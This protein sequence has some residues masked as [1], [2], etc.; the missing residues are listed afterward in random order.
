VPR[1]AALLVTAVLATPA[2]AEASPPTYGER[3]GAHSML[4]LNSTP[5]QHE[6]LFRS[7]S[8]AGLRYLRMDFA[9][10]MVFRWDGTDFTAVDRVNELAARYRIR[11][12]G[13]IAETPWYIAGCTGV[14][15]E[16]L[17]RCAPAAEHE[18]TWRDMV[19]QIVRR[20][21]NV[22]HWELGNEPDDPRTFMGT[23]ADYAR[24]ASLTADGI[25][26]ARPR[27]RI[28]IGG[29]S[30][31]DR[32]YI[33][34]VLRDPANPLLG[35]IDIAN[36]HVRVPLAS[37]AAAVRRAKA[38]YRRIGF[39][40]RLWVTEAGYPSLPAHQWDPA[41]NAGDVDQVRW[42]AH[43]PRQLIA[44]GADVVFVSFRDNH[45]F[46]PDSSFGSE[47]VIAW[48]GAVLKPAYWALLALASMPLPAA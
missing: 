42:M 3:L 1:L 14:P 6:A 38:F 2:A 10:G 26:A 12:L 21:R 33:G 19:F 17:G 32:G 41:M 24:W 45:E 31:L 36:V 15:F 47:G 43:G 8:E 34:A 20:A 23:A 28:A 27:A 7:A 11:V 25:R 22:R 29:F 13:M 9:V 16:L 40:G 39:D 30:R 44:G 5:E 46:G 35:R 48:P 4:Y 37:L 18:A